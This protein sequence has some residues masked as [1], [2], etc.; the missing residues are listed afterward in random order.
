VTQ[1]AGAAL[2][3]HETAE[4]ERLEQ[5]TPEAPA[6]P[7]RQQLSA[8]GCMVPLVGG[9]W[10]EVRTLALGAITQRRGDDGAMTPC[11][12]DISYFSRLADAQTFNRLATLAVHERGTEHAAQVGAVVDGAAWLQEL[13]D[14]HRPDAVRI[15]DFPHAVEHLAQAAQ[16]AFGPGTE[17]ATAWLEA[18]RHELRHGDP[19]VVLAALRALTPPTPAATQT[20]DRVLAYLE[21]RRE[22]ICYAAF[23]A[24]GLPIGSGMVE[25]AN[26]LV[27]E[28]RLKG[29][30]M[31]WARQHVTPM[32]ALRAMHCS[33]RWATA[34]P[35]IWRRLRSQATE[36]R[37]ARRADRQPPAPQTPPPS[38]PPSPPEPAAPR[39]KQVVDGR[40]TADHPW[41][42]LRLPGS[43]DFA[44]IAKN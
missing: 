30:G 44:A 40:P 38:P 42:K 28:A 18:Q 20:R 8:D 19:D 7:E 35:I 6:G 23:R 32:V 31:H 16:A 10:A 41:R 21:Q 34:W 15:L 4:V 11:A 13:I 43:I 1:E 33:R 14:L 24:M 17:R 2:A 12:T 39:E 25:S 26:K 3:A 37:R 27:I 36:R 9:E 29:S 22:Q 5:E